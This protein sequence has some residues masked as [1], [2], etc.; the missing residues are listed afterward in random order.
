M[1]LTP[2]VNSLPAAN[3]ADL[4]VTLQICKVC[5]GNGRNDPAV[6]LEGTGCPW[7]EFNVPGEAVRYPGSGGG[8]HSS[9]LV[10][11]GNYRL[12]GL[13]SGRRI[14]GRGERVV[15]RL[16][17]RCGTVRRAELR[18]ASR[19]WE[20]AEIAWG[21]IPKLRF[22]IG[23]ELPSPTATYSHGCFSE[24]IKEPGDFRKSLLDKA[25]PQL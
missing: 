25:E 4:S 7:T 5:D 20:G 10:A 22:G 24:S 11:E 9:G 17:P 3:G 8:S 15:R 14:P 1:A 21:I 19:P 23:Q 6:N 13:Q 2:F 18:R 12:A 16:R